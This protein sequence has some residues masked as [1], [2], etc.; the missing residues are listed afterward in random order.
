MPLLSTVGVLLAAV[1]QARKYSG[2]GEGTAFG[3]TSPVQSG[4]T[5]GGTAWGTVHRLQMVTIPSLHTVPFVS[6]GKT[7]KDDIFNLVPDLR[8]AL[9][10]PGRLPGEE[11]EQ[12][13]N[14]RLNRF[15]WSQ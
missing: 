6:Y 8:C 15:L 7:F 3:R 5:H 12:G 10:I 2:E 4:E 14:L 1:G 9:S 13:A 11:Y